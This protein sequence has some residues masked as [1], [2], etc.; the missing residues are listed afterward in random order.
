M[1]KLY[2]DG[3]HDD[4]NAIQEMID[5]G[6]CEVNLPVPEKLYLI[7]KTLELPSNCRLVLPRF[8][9]I[10]LADNS[11]CLM[12]KNKTVRDYKERISLPSSASERLRK[13]YPH[14]MYY[15]NEY[16]P[17]A[18]IED[19]EIRGG[20]WNCNNKKQLPNPEQT[21][22]FGPYGYTG[23]GM[24]FFG[25]KNLKISDI[26]LKDPV[27]WGISLDRVSYF[28]VEDITFDYNLGNPCAINMDGVHLNG[29]CHFGV[30][31]NL[32]GACYDDLVAVNAE[33]G[34]KG[35]IT[36]IQID[37][38]FAETC[39]S[40][41]R[42]LAVSSAVENIHISNVYGTYY[43]YCI[44]FTKYYPFETTGYF[45]AITIDHIFASKASRDGIYPNPNSGIYPFIIFEK[46]IIAKNVKISDVYRKE[47]NVA[48]PTIRVERDAVIDNLIIDNLT[49]E[50]HTDSPIPTYEN[51]GIV[52]KLTTKNIIK[53]GK[54]ERIK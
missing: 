1:Y 4:T 26:T 13:L 2:G 53:D 34:S 16:S 8:A 15:V 38:L 17:D 54:I 11:N 40:A 9:E 41:V 35:P 32:K 52:N 24:L 45:D 25:V 39:H 49:V 44:G 10:K 22:G 46:N 18:V 42:L 27:H 20:I 3:I 5:S 12:I 50:N 33:E 7:S 43:Q 28:T 31:K 48:I 30:I 14:L 29:N 23:D 19:I 36:N 37:G 21:E 47:F 51:L 6:R